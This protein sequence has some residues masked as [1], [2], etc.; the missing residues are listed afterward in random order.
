MNMAKIIERIVEGALIILVL[1]IL[2]AIGLGFDFRG[3]SDAWSIIKFCISAFALS[4]AAE[5]IIGKV[6]F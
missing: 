3:I 1:Y 2:A 5:W 6:K 4:Y